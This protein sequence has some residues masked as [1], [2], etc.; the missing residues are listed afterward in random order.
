M[1][2]WFSHL[3]SD[4]LQRREPP[5]HEPVLF[6]ISE[7]VIQLRFSLPA[8]HVLV[9]VHEALVVAGR[10]NVEMEGEAEAV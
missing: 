4:L 5:L 8:Y 1:V 10:Q 7:P 9:F 3:R 6:N 2:V